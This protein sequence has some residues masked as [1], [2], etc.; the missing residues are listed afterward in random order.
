VSTP[1][2]EEGHD[3]VVIGTGFAATFF[4][5]AVL[6]S[7]G[8]DLK[9]LVLERGRRAPHASRLEARQRP[10]AE[11]G[12]FVNKAAIEKDWEFAFGVGGTSQS[13]WACTPRMLPSDFRLRSL[14]GV[15]RDWPVDYDTLE[16][17]YCDAEAL[18][19]VAGPV[20][21]PAPRSRPYPLPSHRL[22]EPDRIL[23]KAHG[24]DFF[25]QPTAR[26][27]RAVPGQR[28]MCCG[29]GVCSL[30]PIDSKFTI[31]NSMADVYR[32]T[33]VRLREGAE[34]LR[35]TTRADVA[36]GV[37]YRHEE[38]I[39]EARGE[40]ILLAANAL[41]NPHVLLRS[42]LDGPE[43]GRGLVE[44][45]SVDVH[46][47]LDGLDNFQ[48][49]T[50][51][52]GHGYTLYDGPHRRDWAGALIETWNV[53]NLRDERG[54][55]RQKLRLKAIFEDLR[56]PENRVRLGKDEGT[57]PEAV[58][59]ARSEY[60]ARGIRALESTLPRFL[61]PLPV[62]RVEIAGT[63]NATE[64]HILGTTVMG[65]DARNSVVDRHGVH[66]R[67]RNLVLLG[68]GNFPTAAPANPTLT[69]AAHAL[70]SA[71]ELH[72]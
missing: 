21:S 60:A 58:F 13:W 52:T 71:R 36:T 32:D 2:N 61:E 35:V 42:G 65:D 9:V 15:G 39:R 24:D 5:H 17:H 45:V 72:T 16:E 29:A 70:W 64:G 63:A 44:Q 25:P 33:R 12:S 6:A 22:S 69:I 8:P 46:V 53:P 66:H 37:V 4:L 55:W 10:G 11:R 56:L 49:G 34:V 19:S 67:V 26:P 3:L 48:G 23:E 51:I 40:L 43:V 38:R 30:C 20:R 18:M 1:S 62:E 68:G 31:I 41:F 54:R 7:A 28:P 47:F 14:Y 27:S 50:S 59:E 57:G